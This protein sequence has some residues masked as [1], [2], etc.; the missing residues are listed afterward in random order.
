MLSFLLSAKHLK[1]NTLGLRLIAV[2]V[3]MVMTVAV[4]ADMVFMKEG[5]DVIVT[6]FPMK[7]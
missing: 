3:D 2:A 7:F 4:A 5:N 6:H 1:H